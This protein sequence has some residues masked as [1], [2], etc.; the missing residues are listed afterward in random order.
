MIINDAR[1]L[2]AFAEIGKIAPGE[3][4]MLKEKA[5]LVTDNVDN[6]GILCIELETG[7]WSRFPRTIR[8]ELRNAKL[9]LE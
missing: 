2:D 3:V 9:I 4:V 8:V 7:A 1:C 6:T 5:F